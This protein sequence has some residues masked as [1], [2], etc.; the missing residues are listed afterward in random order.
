MYVYIS[1]RN[2]MVVGSNPTQAN[3]LYI[4]TYIHTYIIYIMCKRLKKTD[5]IV[6]LL[7]PKIFRCSFFL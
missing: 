5:D 4:Y 2:S 1:E 6:N 3:F 7:F